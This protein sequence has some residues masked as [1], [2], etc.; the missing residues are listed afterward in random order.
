MQF[1]PTTNVILDV[2]LAGSGS[3]TARFPEIAAAVSKIRVKD[4]I[5]D[6]EIKKAQLRVRATEVA[7]QQLTGTINTIVDVDGRVQAT[8][9][10]VDLALTSLANNTR[11]WVGQKKIKKDIIFF[12]KNA[13][14]IQLLGD[15]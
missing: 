12:D 15:C 14:A 13:Q 9:Y 10:Q 8:Y 5:L 2:L 4:A 1:S 7:I 6:G 3:P 11:V